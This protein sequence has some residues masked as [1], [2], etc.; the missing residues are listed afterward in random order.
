MNCF[1]KLHLNKILGSPHVKALELIKIR[2]NFK[3]SV[4]D[5]LLQK[6]VDSCRYRLPNIGIYHCYYSYVED[7]TGYGKYGNLL[8]LDPVTKKRKN[9]ECLL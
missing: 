8:L 9:T 2:E 6:S 1:Q 5:T 7:Q 4:K 3:N